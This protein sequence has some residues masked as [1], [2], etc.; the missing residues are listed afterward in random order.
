MKIEHDTTTVNRE[1]K[2]F[3]E[4]GGT[5]VIQFINGKFDRCDFAIPNNPYRFNDWLFLGEV[6]DLI[7]ELQREE[8]IKEK[9]YAVTLIEEK[10]G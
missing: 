9:G 6:S 3:G 2:M 1:I 5:A 8:N 4:K 10:E 7:K